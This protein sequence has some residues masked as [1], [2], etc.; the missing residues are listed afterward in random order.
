MFSCEFCGIFK[1]TFLYRTPLVIASSDYQFLGALY[2]SLISLSVQKQSC[3]GV[4]HKLILKNLA[5]Q[6]KATPVTESF[7]IQNSGCAHATFLKKDS[8]TYV[9]SSILGN[10]SEQLFLRN[11]LVPSTPNT[12][13]KTYDNK[14]IY[15]QPF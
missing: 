3:T 15:S 9:V 4:L 12:D 1:K 11:S 5:K 8:L 2:F 6:E 10:V 7:F 14:L 13:K